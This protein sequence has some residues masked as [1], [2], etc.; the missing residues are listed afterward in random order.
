MQHI[1]TL[2]KIICKNFHHSNGSLALDALYS[3]L[4]KNDLCHQIDDLK[5]WFAFADKN[6]D[7]KEDQLN[8]Q[9]AAA[10]TVVD[11]YIRERLCQMRQQEEDCE[12]VLGQVGR[13]GENT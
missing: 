1:Q 13:T 12:V 7:E 6:G 3:V 2:V 10:L 5:I 8:V 11:A 4:Y 9:E